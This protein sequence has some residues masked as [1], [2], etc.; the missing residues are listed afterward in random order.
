MYDL[1]LLR[2]KKGFQPGVQLYTA[3]GLVNRKGK[4]G[5]LYNSQGA[6]C[7]ET[8]HYPDGIHHPEWPTCILKAGEEF[9]SYTTYAFSVEN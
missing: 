7:L 9:N 5:V 4:G 8:Q 6:F 3:N 1:S 2:S